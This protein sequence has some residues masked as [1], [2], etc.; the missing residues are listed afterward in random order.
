VIGSNSGLGDT[1]RTTGKYGLDLKTVAGPWASDVPIVDQNGVDIAVGDKLPYADN[2]WYHITASLAPFYYKILEQVIAI[3]DEDGEFAYQAE[4]R[5]IYVKNGGVV[6]K[7][8][9][10]GFFDPAEVARSPSY[11]MGLGSTFVVEQG[12]E[13]PLTVFGDFSADNV[14]APYVSP[15]IT[16]TLGTTYAVPDNVGT[17]YNNSSGGNMT[18]TLFAAA[19]VPAG[20]QIAFLN[21]HA[22]NTLTI[23]AAGSDTINGGT[24]VGPYNQYEGITLASNGSTA[25]YTVV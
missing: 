3:H 24:S 10:D 5:H 1:S 17:V 13:G 15:S 18:M 22:T 11:C 4:Y 19:A 25:F 2:I 23:Q 20:R 9:F 12:V 7:V 16:V 6:R 8:L 21:L 14:T